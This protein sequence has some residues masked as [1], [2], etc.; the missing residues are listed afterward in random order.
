MRVQRHTIDQ[1]AGRRIILLADF[2]LQLFLT[3][4]ALWPA[5]WL[6]RAFSSAA[7]ASWKWVLLILGAFLI[8]VYAYFVALLGVRLVV[9]Y[10]VEGYFPRG[11]GGRPPREA[12]IYMMN[13]FLSK[14]R[15]QPPWTEMLG[16]AIVNTFPLR[17]L[18][19]RFFGPHRNGNHMGSVV[20]MP[21]PYLVWAGEN[22]VFGGGCLITCHQYDQRGLFVKRVI[23][24]DDVTIGAGAVIAPGVK[25]RKGA[26]IA[27]GAFV[28]PNTVVGENELWAGDPARFVKKIRPPGRATASPQ[29]S[30][31]RE[32]TTVEQTATPQ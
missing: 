31:D 22:V 32:E 2:A 29:S 26:M 9:P 6:V 28:R 12:A 14:A 11:R 15:Y 8:F 16:V 30:Q 25:I 10:P 18:Y 23:V 7:D 4:M 1:D 24:E 21:D 27:F 3:G 17:Q 19:K 20:L 5:I 13:V